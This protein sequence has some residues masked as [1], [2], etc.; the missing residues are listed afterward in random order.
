[1]DF[2]GG[3]G[4]SEFWFARKKYAHLSE[5]VWAR[6]TEGGRA[7]SGPPGA[8]MPDQRVF[9]D[10]LA[11]L[12][13]GGCQADPAICPKCQVAMEGNKCRKCGFCYGCG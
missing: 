11:A 1:M 12:P 2:T 6:L 5:D 8:W 13:D 4:M 3:G 7:T 9:L 10:R